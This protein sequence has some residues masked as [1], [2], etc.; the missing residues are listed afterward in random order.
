[1]NWIDVGAIAFVALGMLFGFRKGLILSFSGFIGIGLAIWIGI[2]FS[3]I[4]ENYVANQDLI[5]ESWVSIVALLVMIFLV[6]LSWR[7]LSKILHKVVH[8]IGLGLLNRLGGA[9]FGGSINLLIITA[10][11]YVLSP[12]ISSLLDQEIINQ[13]QCLPYLEELAHL[14]IVSMN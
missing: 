11:A 6:Y 1:M 12:I 10:F 14:L 9:L 2:N 3:N 5:P 7:I 4:L 8:T 13:S